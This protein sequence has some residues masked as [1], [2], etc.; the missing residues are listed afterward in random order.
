MC[1]STYLC[2]VRVDAYARYYRFIDSVIS[3][4]FKVNCF[5]FKIW[6]TVNKNYFIVKLLLAQIF[7]NHYAST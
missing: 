2:A 7:V 4:T 1:L 6:T 5:Y 3:M